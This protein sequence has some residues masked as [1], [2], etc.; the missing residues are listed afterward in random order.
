MRA[1]PSDQAVADHYEV[2]GVDRDAPPEEIKRAFRRLARATHPDANPDDP[3]AE[4]RF[5][6]VAEAYEVLSD[7]EKRARYDRGDHLDLG[8]LF[9]GPGSVDDLFRSVFEGGGLFGGSGL[10]G[11]GASESAN[12]RGRDIRLH[13]AID[14]VEAAFGAE[15]TVRFRAAV[16]CE[17][18]SG[19]G[20]R[21]GSGTRSCNVCAGTGQV[22]MA[23]RSALGSLMTVTTCRA[24]RGAGWVI[25]DP[26]LECRGEGIAE[27]EKEVSV[28]V[29]TGVSEDTRLRIVGDGE[30]GRQ[31]APPGDLYIELAVK[32]HQTFTRH[33][34]DLLY[35][36]PV[37]IAAAALG[38][39]AEVPLLEGG[40]EEIKVPAGTQH[41]DVIR[42]RGRGTG[43]L[44]RRGR[45]DL[46][47]RM[48]ID[49][50]TR[51]SRAER[52][53]LRLYAEARG[54]DVL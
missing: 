19:S 7:P 43:R 11:G 33:G 5:R 17:P 36:L 49:V 42:V 35:D 30:A 9:H 37:G 47:V 34:D 8:G 26:C 40:S 23:R 4:A 39:Q 25:A 16:A 45:G 44:R 3:S 53:I 51:M 54:E 50:P 6:Q 10:F 1:E 32:P 41:G 31:G 38:T 21:S 14:L 24:C 2:L 29:P 28:D 12:A 20:A 22:R 18:C 52:K 27:G 46:L 13:L 15:R 48:G